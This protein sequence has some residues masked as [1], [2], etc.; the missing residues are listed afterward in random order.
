VTGLFQ[1]LILPALAGVQKPLMLRKAMLS[2]VYVQEQPEPGNF[3]QTINVN[4]PVVN[5]SDAIDIGNGPI[6]I[7]DQDHTT[8]PLVVNRNLSVSK[9]IR[10]FD[11]A[12][13]PLAFRQFY[14]QP[15]IEALARKINRQVCNLVT[16][17]NFP[18]YT[19]ITGEADAFSRV[20]VAAAWKN[21]AG[22]GVPMDVGE[23]AFVTHS[24]PYGN[25]LGDDT[26]KWIQENV[27]GVNAAEAAQQTAKL[28]PAFGFLMD[29]DPQLPL[30]AAGT[31]AALAFNKNAIAAVPVRVPLEP[32]PAVEESYFTLPGTS[33]LC[34][35][36][37]G[38]S[39]EQQCYILHVHCIFALA[40][41]RPDYGSFLVS[42]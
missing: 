8:V 42:T 24:T 26:F 16:A 12:R 19:S 13:T 4:I 32:K 14:A 34:R 38:Y 39:I 22:A 28:M 15:A 31:F 17:A 40:V 18:T 20:N 27:V 7:S 5:E 35:V 41:V 25:M 3:G 23:T 10:D 21:L 33:W 37:Y 30:P 9:A 11:K 2:K 36:Q 29:W 1:T 6:Q